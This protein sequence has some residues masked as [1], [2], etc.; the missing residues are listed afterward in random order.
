[1]VQRRLGVED[2]RI[3]SKV[4]KVAVL[5]EG[6]DDHPIE[7]EGQQH[8]KNSQNDHLQQRRPPGADSGSAHQATSARWAIRNISHATITRSGTRNNETAAP[9]ARS[10]PRIPVK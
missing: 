6:G 5:L 3:V 10:L 8:R 2:E 7:R 9:A 1:M 4:V